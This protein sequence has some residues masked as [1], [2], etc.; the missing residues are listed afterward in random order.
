MKS[1]LW[2]LFT[3]YSRAITGATIAIFSAVALIGGYFAVH[4]FLLAPIT[5]SLDKTL[6]SQQQDLAMA[7]RNAKDL[8]SQPPIKEAGAAGRKVI[9]QL[10]QLVEDEAFREGCQ[11]NQFTA[12]AK[13]G[14]YIPHYGTEAGSF[15][16]FHVR[17]VVSG[18]LGRVFSLLQIVSDA[19]VPL[20]FTAMMLAPAGLDSDTTSATIEM[21]VLAKPEDN[22]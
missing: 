17:M 16:S 8:K 10:Q 15:R 22:G 3:K 18:N 5:A 6:K 1:S 20:E 12:P 4:L 9:D 11:V 14:D 2:I 21:D 7:E 13:S 19:P